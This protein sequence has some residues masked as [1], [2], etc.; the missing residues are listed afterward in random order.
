MQEAIQ[1]RI[2]TWHNN[3]KFRAV[4]LEAN[5]FFQADSEADLMLKI[6]DGV[7]GYLDCFTEPE[8]LAK[9][10]LRPAPLKY[11]VMW[12]IKPLLSVINSFKSKKANYNII[13]GKL[14]FA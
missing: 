6:R 9:A 3:I 7:K 14:K 4:C 11:R 5:L 2:I 10:Y 8:I 12:L 1:L 13:S